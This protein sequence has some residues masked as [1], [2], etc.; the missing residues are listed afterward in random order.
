MKYTFRHSLPAAYESKPT[1]TA[2][3]SD[4]NAC[5]EQE[6]LLCMCGLVFVSLSVRVHVCMSA[7]VCVC[8]CAYV[9]VCVCSGPS[10]VWNVSIAVSPLIF[11]PRKHSL[12]NVIFPI[13]AH[14]YTLHGFNRVPFDKSLSLPSSQKPCVINL[15]QIKQ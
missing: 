8:V 11:P 5:A 2:V 7:C 4:R 1:P 10:V 9:C 3:M 15:S 14:V 13:C 12:Q 6:R